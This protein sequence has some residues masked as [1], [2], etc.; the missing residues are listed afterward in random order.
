MQIVKDRKRR[1]TSRGSKSQSV[2][3]FINYVSLG[4]LLYFTKLEILGFLLL[5][6]LFFHLEITLVQNFS[7]PTQYLNVTI[8]NQRMEVESKNIS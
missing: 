3:R 1:C 6:F 8:K 5:L 7:V 4:Q 2:M